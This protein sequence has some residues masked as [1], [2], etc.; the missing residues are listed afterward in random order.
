[1]KDKTE[2]LAIIPARGNSKSIPRKNICEFAGHPLIA[3]SIAAAKQAKSV[4]R[5]IVS[6]D[7]PEIAQVSKRYGAEVPFMRPV[8]IAEDATLDLPVFEH[9]LRWLSEDENYSPDVVVQLRPTSPIRPTDMVDKAVELLLNH[10]EA[11]SVR[12]VVLS[13]QNPFKMWEIDSTGV[14]HPLLKVKEIKEPYNAPRQD[15]PLTYWQTGHIDAIRPRA[16]LEKSSMSGD[17]VLPLLIDPIYTVDID[18]LLDWQRA[19]STVLE[20]LLDIV[21]PSDHKRKLPAMVSLLVM[22]FDGVLTDDRVWVD[23]NGNEMV[24]SNRADGLGLERLRGLTNIQAMVLSKETNRVVA[25]RCKKLELP[26]IQSVQDKPR[27]LEALI[28]QRGVKKEEVV[29][30]GND[31][32][33]LECFPLVGFA[34]APANAQPE[35]SRRAD[36]M[37]K[38]AGGFGAVR[39]LCELLIARY[40]KLSENS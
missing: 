5:V 40:S 18:T 33:D 9:A 1:M 37:L 15:L 23:Q 39:E 14:M 20:G 25:A 13:G 8:E 12:G 27:T 11:D 30:I 32:N 7:D 26:V 19:E 28:K 21:Y 16:I 3:F 2:V 4:T 6:T 10:P 31:L 36:L 38:S 34:A 35:V 22:D 29:Y 17:V 24:A